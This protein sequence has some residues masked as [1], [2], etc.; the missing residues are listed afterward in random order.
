MKYITG[1]IKWKETHTKRNG[2]PKSFITSK[3]TDSTVKNIS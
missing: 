1:K 3:E 2:K